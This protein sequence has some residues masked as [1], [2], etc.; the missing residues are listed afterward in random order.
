MLDMGAGPIATLT[1]RQM[2][3][4]GE[5]EREQQEERRRQDGAKARFFSMRQNS[6]RGLARVD[7]EW[8]GGEGERER[9]RGRDQAKRKA[10]VMTNSCRGVLGRLL[11]GVRRK[12]LE[13]FYCKGVTAFAAD[14]AD[15]PFA[16]T[17]HVVSLVNNFSMNTLGHLENWKVRLEAEVNDLAVSKHIHHAN[18]LLEVSSEDLLCSLTRWP[19][20]LLCVSLC[21]RA[22]INCLQTV[23]HIKEYVDHLHDKI[24]AFSIEA[25]N[26]Q[27]TQSL[28]E[29]AR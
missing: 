6:L 9:E 27:A 14:I 25:A 23:Q 16:L 12:L 8:K 10:R 11:V 4:E 21:A 22:E 13:N 17:V 7:G 2:D 28:K 20:T 5:W 18:E 1:I 24:D 26:E 19:L 3:D 15:G 29:G